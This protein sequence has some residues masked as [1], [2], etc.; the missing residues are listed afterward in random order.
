MLARLSEK[1]NKAIQFDFE[2]LFKDSNLRRNKL[3][4][5]EIVRK[6]END[7]FLNKTSAT[8]FTLK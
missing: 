6:R 4:L 1:G 3:V 5:E 7:E 8:L 2:R